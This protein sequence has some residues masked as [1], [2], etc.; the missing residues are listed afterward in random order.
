M[1][2]LCTEIS[3][4][5]TGEVHKISNY[6]RTSENQKGFFTK[7]TIYFNELACVEHSHLDENSVFHIV[8]SLSRYSAGDVLDT[9]SMS[10]AI[11]VFESHLISS[12]DSL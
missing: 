11:Q 5:C 2:W 3:L 12:T 10:R 4:R 7:L 9:T 1:E 6:F 8:D